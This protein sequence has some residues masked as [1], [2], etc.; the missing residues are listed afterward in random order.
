MQLRKE[1]FFFLVFPFYSMPLA[2]QGTRWIAGLADLLYYWGRARVL[3]KKNSTDQKIS[4]FDIAKI[5]GPSDSSA[6]V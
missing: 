4:Y 2:R 3:L 5:K 6:T 1:R